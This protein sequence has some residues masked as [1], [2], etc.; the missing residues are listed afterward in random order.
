MEPPT[1]SRKYE[2]SFKLKVIKMGKE[3]NDCAAAR[4][5]DVIEKREKCGNL[6][7]MDG[8]EGDLLRDTDDEVE[9]DLPDIEWDP[10]DDTVN[11]ES[12]DMLDE[13][14]ASATE[15]VDFARF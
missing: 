7:A 4:A 8:T 3:S 11:S 9:T 2:A 15:C 6:N 1:K 10:Y 13:L 14:F 5:F 12:Q